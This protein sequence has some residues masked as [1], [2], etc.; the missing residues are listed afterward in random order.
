[1]LRYDFDESW[2][3]YAG[4][5]FQSLTDLEQSIGARAARLNQ[6][7]TFFLLAGVSFRF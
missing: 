3:V 2:G 6:G 4:A 1:M 7:A 5:Q